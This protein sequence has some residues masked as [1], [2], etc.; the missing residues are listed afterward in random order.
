MEGIG[1]NSMNEKLRTR[2]EILK[3][4]LYCVAG[5][6]TDHNDRNYGDEEQWYRHVYDNYS[7]YKDLDFDIKDFDRKE[8]DE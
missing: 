7:E 3:D 8:T 6:M 2:K 4:I 1:E 5:A